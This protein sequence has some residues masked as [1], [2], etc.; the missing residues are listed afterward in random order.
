MKENF[1][2]IKMLFFL[3]F[4]LSCADLAA[5][6][7][8]RNVAAHHVESR[9]LAD[10]KVSPLA[11]IKLKMLANLIKNGKSPILTKSFNKIHRRYAKEVKNGARLA[12]F[13][14]NKY[15]QYQ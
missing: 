1:K 13:L 9:I 2:F 14:T 7:R 4:S 3:L 10:K 15:T 11:H 8:Y 6:N 12:R 5:F